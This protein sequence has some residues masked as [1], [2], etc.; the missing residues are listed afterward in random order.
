VE[1]LGAAALGHPARCVAWL[2]NKLASF[3]VTLKSG[4][5]VLSGALGMSIPARRGDVFV[6]EVLGQPPLTTVFA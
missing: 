6:L 4:D 3:D 2:A 1:G 5:V